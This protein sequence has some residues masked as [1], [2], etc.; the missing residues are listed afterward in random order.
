MCLGVVLVVGLRAPAVW[1]AD[2]AIAVGYLLVSA[3]VYPRDRRLAAMFIVVGFL[4][5]VIA[6]RWGLSG[7]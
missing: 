3:I 4:F 2:G 5:L 6:A 7:R 1:I